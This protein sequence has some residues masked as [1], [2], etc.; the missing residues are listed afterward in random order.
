MHVLLLAGRCCNRS[1]PARCALS[2][3]LVGDVWR[4]IAEV[5]SVI[6]KRLKVMARGPTRQTRLATRITTFPRRIDLYFSGDK[7]RQAIWTIIA[8][9]GGFYAGNTVSI[10][11]YCRQSAH[12]GFVSDIC[13]ELSPPSLSVPMV[14]SCRIVAQVYHQVAVAYPISHC[15]LACVSTEGHLFYLWLLAGIPIFWSFGN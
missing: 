14:L 1:S 9:G 11:P 7:A 2:F 10:S 4:S 15:L 8:F 3:L 12:L 6:R 5:F 13:I